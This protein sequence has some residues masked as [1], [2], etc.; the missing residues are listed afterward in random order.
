MWKVIGGVIVSGLIAWGAWATTSITSK[1]DREVH[2]QDI[3]EL[4][5]EQMKQNDKMIDRLEKI[6]EKIK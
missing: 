1:T 3:R 6:W 4:R 2:D 5:T